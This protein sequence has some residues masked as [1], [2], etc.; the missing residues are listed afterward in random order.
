MEAKP[1]PLSAVVH[2]ASPFIDRAN[3]M[4]QILLMMPEL[5]GR[6][7]IDRSSSRSSSRIALLVDSL[8]ISGTAGARSNEIHTHTHTTHG[9]REKNGYSSRGNATTS[10][11][12]YGKADSYSNISSAT[13]TRSKLEMLREQSTVSICSDKARLRTESTF[14]EYGRI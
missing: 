7:Q 9:A 13:A 10:S 6:F 12:G 3:R 11:S 14:G 1:A 8:Q 2:P 4:A 5:F